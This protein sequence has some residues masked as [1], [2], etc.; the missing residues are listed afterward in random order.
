MI[1]PRKLGVYLVV[2]GGALL[3][4]WLVPTLYGAAMS[5]AAVALFRAQS[6]TNRMWDSA[7]IRAYKQTL[8]MSFAPPEAILR[9]PKL[10]VEVPIF[11]GTSD[12]ILNRGVGRI[13]GTAGPGEPGNYAVTGHRDGFFRPLKD[14]A[15][16]DVVEVERMEH[17][18]R[19]VDRYVVRKLKIVLP[20]DISVLKPAERSTLTLITCYP[21][22]YLGSAPQRFVVQADLLPS[23]QMHAALAAHS[24]QPFTGE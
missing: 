24:V 1:W 12:A 17:Q 22:F 9:I 23:P 10:G 16:G 19:V 7:R 18:S 6:T 20:S 5:H 15:P 8:S 14:I 13:A 21:F 2:V 4:V 3:S 11:E